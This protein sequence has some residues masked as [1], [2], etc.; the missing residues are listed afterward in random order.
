MLFATAEPSGEEDDAIDHP[1]IDLGTVFLDL[2]DTVGNHLIQAGQAWAANGWDGTTVPL[3]EA[4]EA[5]QDYQDKNDPQLW[6]DIAL[7]LEDV[8]SIEGCSSV[9]PPASIPNWIAIQELLSDAGEEEL[10]S[11]VGRLVDS[12]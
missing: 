1:L 11:I 5:L 6:R 10:A 7:E 2:D 12:I 4:S 9:G 8:G 3:A